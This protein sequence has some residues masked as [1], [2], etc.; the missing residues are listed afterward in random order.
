MSILIH[1][2]HE[3]QRFNN[4]FS[5]NSNCWQVPTVF[6]TGNTGAMFFCMRGDQKYAQEVM[7]D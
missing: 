6:R 2:F 3:S 5:S 1:T 4:T 7:K